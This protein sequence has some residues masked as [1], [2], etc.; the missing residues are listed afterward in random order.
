MHK[1]PQ[2]VT[3]RQAQPLLIKGI[4]ADNWRSANNDTI[5]RFSPK[6]VCMHA[7]VRVVLPLMCLYAAVCMLPL[8]AAYGQRT[9]LIHLKC[10]PFCYC[11]W[12]TAALLHLT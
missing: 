8:F 10:L 2:N 12:F 11:A 9:R 3:L 5:V 6:G 1:L 7:L 4:L